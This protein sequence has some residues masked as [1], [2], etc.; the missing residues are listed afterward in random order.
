MGGFM[1]DKTYRVEFEMTTFLDQELFIEKLY[2]ALG[3]MDSLKV[4]Q[5]HEL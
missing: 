1:K 2:E 4:E 5:L 3:H